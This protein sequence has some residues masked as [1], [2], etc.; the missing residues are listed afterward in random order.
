MAKS[1]TQEEKADAQEV[2][3]MKL[4]LDNVGA[5]TDEIYSRVEG[6]QEQ[7][8]A[9]NETMKRMESLLRE[10][11]GPSTPPATSDPRKEAEAGQKSQTQP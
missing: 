7:V 9:L 4:D 2:A 11:Q 8:T 10:K 3:A 5:R 6:M 1:K